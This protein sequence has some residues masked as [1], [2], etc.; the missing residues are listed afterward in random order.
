MSDLIKCVLLHIVQ[1]LCHSAKH[2][3]LGTDIEVYVYGLWKCT[4]T[5]I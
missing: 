3:L 5:G 1:M 4:I 2:C